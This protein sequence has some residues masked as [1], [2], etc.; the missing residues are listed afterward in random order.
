MHENQ[1]MH[2]YLHTHTHTHTAEGSSKT[3]PLVWRFWLY[4]PLFLNCSLMRWKYISAAKFEKEALIG[5]AINL[6]IWKGYSNGSLPF[7]FS[8]KLMQ[9]MLYL[10]QGRLSFI[11]PELTEIKSDSNLIKNECH[12]ILHGAEKE[13]KKKRK[14]R[15]IIR[16]HELP[17]RICNGAKNQSSEKRCEWRNEGRKTSWNKGAKCSF[18]TFFAHFLFLFLLW[19]KT[20]IKT[21]WKHHKT[22]KINTIKPE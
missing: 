8:E 18:I 4:T 10:L 5:K 17:Q 6:N 7:L 19:S 22:T 12:C 16:K 15:Q 3:C 21:W 11:L 14:E 1:Y 2:M 13:R 20:V 9:R